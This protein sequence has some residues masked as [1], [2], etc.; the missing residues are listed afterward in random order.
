[1]LKEKGLLGITLIKTD[2]DG[3]VDGTPLEVSDDLTRLVSVKSN[4]LIDK[5]ESLTQ[6]TIRVSNLDNMNID[7]SMGRQ[8]LKEPQKG[9]SNGILT[10]EKESLQGLPQKLDPN[11]IDKIESRF[12]TSDAFVQSNDYR[13]R[14]FAVKAVSESDTS[15]EKVKKLVAWIQKNIKRQPVISLPNALSTLESRMGD[16]NEHAALLAAFCRAIG[17]PAKIEAGMVY[18]NGRFY[19]HAWNVVFIGRWITVDALFNQIPADVTHIS[20]SSGS[21]DMQLD[22]VGLI[23]RVQI[24]VLE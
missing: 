20:F 10:I 5:P 14:S 23:G 9:S 15:L 24:E 22:I 16:C 13:I 4:K 18:L 1:V 11:M 6:L 19:Y 21:N 17:I 2:R 3:A 8:T 7:L 12:R